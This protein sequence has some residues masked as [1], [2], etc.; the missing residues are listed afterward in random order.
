MNGQHIALTLSMNS[1]STSHV[2]FR[3]RVAADDV[4]TS[5]LEISTADC[6]RELIQLHHRE[7]ATSF[8]HVDSFD[9][10]GCWPNLEATNIGKEA[11][12]ALV[13]F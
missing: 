2:G 10:F 3:R 11:E 9:G 7:N 5:L 1:R 12:R 4:H 13:R 6:I 8:N